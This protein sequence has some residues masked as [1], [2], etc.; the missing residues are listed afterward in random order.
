MGLNGTRVNNVI[1]PQRFLSNG[2]S[3]WIHM[4]SDKSIVRRG[5]HGYYRQSKSLGVLTVR[6]LVILTD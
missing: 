4:H 5:F 2:S 3:L 1:E 6:F